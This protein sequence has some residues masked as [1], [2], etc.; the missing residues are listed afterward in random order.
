[1]FFLLRTAFWLTL[2]LLL[3]PLGSNRDTEPSEAI[4]PVAAYFAAQA[5]VADFGGFC[6]RN[7]GACETGGE[8]L[9]AI[10][11]QARD[12]ARIVYEF[13]D[14]Q[15][16]EPAEAEAT[17]VAAADRQTSNLITGSTG[18]DAAAGTLTAED[19]VLPWQ[20]EAGSLASQGTDTGPVPRPNPR[21]GNG[22]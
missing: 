22:I 3:I 4:D 11:A 15:F 12:G 1:M 21:S 14:T 16:S 17:L 8:A 20:G 6:G 7:P 5:T 10:G 2:V 18:L 9:A 19:V 13:L